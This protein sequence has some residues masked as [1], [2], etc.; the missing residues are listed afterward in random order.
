MA[1]VSFVVVVG[2]ENDVWAD[3]VAVAVLFVWMMMIMKLSLSYSCVG[4]KN[5]LLFESF[6]VP[7]KYG[8]SLQN[9][10]FLKSSHIFVFFVVVKR[11]SFLKVKVESFWG[12][13]KYGFSL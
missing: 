6:W 5:L 9:D 2:G 4:R 1:V 8:F 7:E 3:A 10:S 13:E 12:Y 11:G